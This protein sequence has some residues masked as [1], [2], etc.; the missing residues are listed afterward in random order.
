MQP[1][2]HGLDTPSLDQSY[3]METSINWILFCIQVV[4]HSVTRKNP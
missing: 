4:L 3:S 1:M 2:G